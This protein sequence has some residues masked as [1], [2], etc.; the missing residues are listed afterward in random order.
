M[1][2]LFDEYQNTMQQVRQAREQAQLLRDQL[3]AEYRRLLDQPDESSPPLP[4]SSPS[5]LGREAMRKAIAAVDCALAS[6]DQALREM[7]R[8][9]DDPS[10]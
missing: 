2:A 6:I 10:H 9:P 1:D 4:D 3:M 7:Q 8:V 5:R